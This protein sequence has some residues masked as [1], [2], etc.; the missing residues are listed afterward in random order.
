MR[1]EAQ[2]SA[3]TPKIALA[4]ALRLLEKS[5]LGKQAE[6]KDQESSIRTVDSQALAGGPLLAAESGR[7]FNSGAQH[8]LPSCLMAGGGSM[9][10]ALAN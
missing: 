9:A 4:L 10:K 5:P 3:A 1:G 7:R 2:T 6:H 8:P